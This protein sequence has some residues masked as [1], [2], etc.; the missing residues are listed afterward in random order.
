MSDK[1]LHRD[2]APFGESVWEQIDQAIISTAKAQMSGRRLLRIDGPHGIELNAVAT[3]EDK[4]ISS[5][6]D[7]GLVRVPSL[8]P[9]PS[10]ESSFSLPIRAVAAFEKNR[11]SL[12]LSA[13]IR[14]VTSC[15]ELE[16]D[17]IFNGLEAAKLSGL[18]NANGSQ[19]CKLVSW[20]EVGRAVDNVIQAVTMLD[21]AGFRGPY[22]LAL[23]PERHNQLFRRYPQGSQTELDHLKEVVPDG[24]VK[25]SAIKKGGVLV[26]NSS[27]YASIA[28][29]QDLAASFIGPEGRDYEFALSETA[30]LRLSSPESVC[31]LK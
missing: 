1:Y 14:A 11:E 16:D 24:V 4:L 13:A 2:D 17:L 7:N 5:K 20:D 3:G 12:D 29:G 8:I 9:V 22:A 6:G 28:I 15:A 19:S 10:L 26:S 31:T 18:L 30:V 23:S 27:D 21:K 25:S